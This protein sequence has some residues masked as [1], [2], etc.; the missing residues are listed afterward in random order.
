[1]RTC[2]RYADICNID[3][4][5]PGSP[6]V[7]THKI[8]VLKQH[9]EAIGRDPGQIKRTVLIPMRLTDDETAAKAELAR[10]P[11]VLAGNPAYCIDLIGKYID[12]GA[13]EIMFSGVPTKP[14]LW[15][16]INADVLSAFD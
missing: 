9:C 4:N 13:E 15:E 2:A 5:N 7:F 8:N 10:R 6:D 16:R 12:A 3:F 11:W 1:M 14:E